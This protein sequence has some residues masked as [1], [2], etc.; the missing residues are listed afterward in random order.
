MEHPL[1]HMS[2]FVRTSKNQ[3]PAVATTAMT[4]A[5]PPATKFP[6]HHYRAGPDF[7][8][9]NLEKISKKSAEQALMQS[10]FRKVTYFSVNKA[11]SAGTTP[12][13][14]INFSQSF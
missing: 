12:L 10:Q 5:N 9:Q 14:F 11:N 4:L 13:I 2:N 8:S 3:P 7:F 6:T 1:C